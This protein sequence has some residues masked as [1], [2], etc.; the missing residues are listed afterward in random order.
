MKI[1]LR[2][3]YH[4]AGI[5]VI[6]IDF[7]DRNDWDVAG[8]YY[9]DFHPAQSRFRTMFSKLVILAAMALPF[10]T[11]AAAQ[12]PPNCDRTYTVQLGDV[13]D[14]ISAANNVST[15]QLAHVNPGINADCSNLFEGE[16]LCLGVAGEDCQT[17]H[18]VVSGD[19]CPTIAAAANISDS[20]LLSNNPNVNAQCS[21]IGI[22]EVLCTSST[23]IHYT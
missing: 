15:F 10:L 1:R 7:S 18:V 13:C 16:I 6:P 8:R 14:S 3:V 21:N 20:T 2:S 19:L 23:I 12:L 5:L 9:G 11:G 22:G 4:L 17:I